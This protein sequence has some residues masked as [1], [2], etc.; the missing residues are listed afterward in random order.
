MV[1]DDQNVEN[2]VFDRNT[3]IFTKMLV[4][5]AVVIFRVRV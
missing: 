5:V 2:G 3:Y 1:E 4:T